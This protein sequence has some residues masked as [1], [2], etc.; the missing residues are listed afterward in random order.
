MHVHASQNNNKIA[1]HLNS[2]KKMSTI[3]TALS[4]AGCNAAVTSICA[5]HRL[6][7]SPHLMCL[8]LACVPSSFLS[9][10]TERVPNG[11]RSSASYIAGR[12]FD[13]RQSPGFLF[14]VVVFLSDV[15]WKPRPVRLQLVQ[16]D[17]RFHCS[18]VKNLPWM[19]LQRSKLYS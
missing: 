17:K 18:S 16:E 12:A 7:K 10:N 2:H 5:V 4:A 6:M 19:P 11:V 1:D 14:V 15:K 13:P 9:L 3:S 8:P